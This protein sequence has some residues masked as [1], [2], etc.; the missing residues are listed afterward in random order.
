MADPK[1]IDSP[2]SQ[3]VVLDGEPLQVCI[4]RLER[5]KTWTLEVVDAAGTSTVWEDRFTSDRDALEEALTAI[6]E[7][8]LEA[9]KMRTIH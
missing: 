4:Y 9:F 5:Q 6:R 2:L 1:L 8:G 7:E 3:T